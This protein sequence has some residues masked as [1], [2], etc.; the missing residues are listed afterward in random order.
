M[1]VLLQDL[2]KLEG[3]NTS[4]ACGSNLLLLKA[5]YLSISNKH[6]TTCDTMTRGETC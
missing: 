1:V 6:M 5:C 2:H 4:K 3:W